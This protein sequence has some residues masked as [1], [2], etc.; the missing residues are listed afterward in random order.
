MWG[1]D[2]DFHRGMIPRN[3][4]FAREY[5]GIYEIDHETHHSVFLLRIRLGDE[6]GEGRE[7]CLVDLHFTIFSEAV[8]I[9]FE[10]P[11]EEKCSDTLVPIRKWMILDDEVE[12]MCCLLFDRR[13]EILSV[14]GSAVAN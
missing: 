10:E 4:L 11:Y 14:E 8:C 13:V 6:E 1:D 12:E 3:T 5:L 9:A 2:W 7:T